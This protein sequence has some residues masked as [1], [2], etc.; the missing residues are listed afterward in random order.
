MATI[1]NL[2]IGL[3]VDFGGVTKGLNRGSKNLRGG[4]S[5]LRASFSGMQGIL[6]RMQNTAGRIGSALTNAIK[7]ATRSGI[8]LAAAAE[9]TQISFEVMLGSAEQAA[10][11]WEQIRDFAA[12]TPFESVELT[13]AAKQL[14]AFGTSAEQVIPTLRA[15]GDLASGSGQPIG[16]LAAIY[17]KARV[18][19]RLFMEDVNQLGDRNINV[20]QVWSEKLGKTVPEIRQMVSEGRFGFSDLQ[21]AIIEL[22][23]EGGKFG[24]MMERQ[25]TT[26]GGLWSTTIDNAKTAAMGFGA[27][28]LDWLDAKDALA[29]LNS[30]FGAMIDTFQGM[31]QATEDN[32]KS[33]TQWAEVWLD[34]AEFVVRGLAHVIDFFGFLKDFWD[35]T[36]GAFKGGIGIMIDAL[37]SFL[38]KAEAVMNRLPE[39]LGGGSANFGA[40]ALRNTAAEWIREG[41]AAVADAVAD[42]SKRTNAEA[43][44]SFFDQVRESLRQTATEAMRTTDAV[45]VV[46]DAVSGAGE[47]LSARAVARMEQQ[48]GL[49]KQLTRQQHDDAIAAA[50]RGSSEAFSAIRQFRGQGR[51]DPLRQMEKLNEAALRELELQRENNRLIRDALNNLQAAEV[52]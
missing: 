6:D 43:V 15:L 40:A 27:A 37:A 16:E 10:M 8:G 38:E 42:M 46:Q 2:L 26:L 9:Q 19:G 45:E 33:A 25:S 20:L 32:S 28:L 12:A 35:L 17:G 49:A 50:T 23:K 29:G 36:V 39:A 30:V 14:I 3:G 11:L 7:T 41:D 5:N 44:T 18:A 4:I 31:Q 51:N 48:L 21:E 34:G 47:K 1:A 13:D 22:T 52:L 24:G